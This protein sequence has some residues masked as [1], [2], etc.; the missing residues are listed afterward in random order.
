MNKEIE[1]RNVK[2]IED[3]VNSKNA[4]STAKC[5]ASDVKKFAEFLNKYLL[6]TTIIDINT[7]FKSEEIKSKSSATKNRY[8]ASLRDFFGFYI[9]T[10]DYTKNNPL[11]R[12]KNFSVDKEGQTDPL[13]IEQSRD[14]IKLLKE[15]VKKADS[16]FQKNMNI[17]NL[18]I[19]H[20]LIN[21]GFRVNELLELT[22]DR[23]FLEELTI[24]LMADDTKGKKERIVKLPK[25]SIEYIKKYLDI[26]NDILKGKESEYVF[27]SKSGNLFDSDTFD[28]TLK[29][30]GKEIG[31]EGLRSHMFR[32]TYIT[33]IYNITGHDLIKTQN[34]IVH[35]D[36]AITRRYIKTYED[37]DALVKQLP[38]ARL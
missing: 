25:E 37:N 32:A 27:V 5:Y 1:K 20:I 17:R 28:K 31:I 38:T 3:Y 4:D 15:K 7:Y 35:S 24:K 8:I 10:E 19:I 26:R 13:T 21:G 34:I 33:N 22:F 14:L 16:N 29:I 2:L 23:L 30:Y 18:A 11:C 12:Q 6:E 36:I 9:D